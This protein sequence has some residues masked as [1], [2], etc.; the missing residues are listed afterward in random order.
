MEIEI[1]DESELNPINPAASIISFLAQAYD[2]FQYNAEI[3][4]EG[5]DEETV[6]QAVAKFKRALKKQMEAVDAILPEPEYMVTLT[7][8]SEEVLF[9][10]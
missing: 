2:R 1:S 3:N 9:G 5:L 8:T 10:E 4:I 7:L 6:K